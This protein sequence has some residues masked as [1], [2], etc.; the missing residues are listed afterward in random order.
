M[1]TLSNVSLFTLLYICTLRER[2]ERKLCG[3]LNS[4][5]V[6]FAEGSQFFLPVSPGS[7]N[8]LRGV[9]FFY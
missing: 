9:N 8:F 3:L 2:C 6:H 5:S 4:L 7:D 1:T